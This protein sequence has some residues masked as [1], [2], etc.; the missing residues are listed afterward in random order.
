MKPRTS[1][2]AGPRCTARLGPLD[3]RTAAWREDLADIAL[4]PLIAVQAYSEPMVMRVRAKT[5]PLRDAP[6]ADAVAVSELLYGE[7]FAVFDATGGQVWGYGLHDHYVGYADL[8]V[9]E[10][11]GANA[12]GSEAAMVGPGDALVFAQPRLKAPVLATLPMAAQVRI[13]AHNEHFVQLAGGHHDGG[14]VHRRH[15]MHGDIDWVAIAQS[16]IGAPYRWGGRTR[17]G[18]DCSGLI[19]IAWQMAGRTARRDSDMLIADAGDPVPGGAYQRGDIAWWPGHI[20]V[21]LDAETLLHAN[22]HWMA[23]VQEPLADV[24]A[25]AARAGGVSEPVVKRPQ[26]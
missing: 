15:L 25:R 24:V 23:T 2:V 6:G 13:R 22:A 26:A 18:V 5:A 10:P 8:A 14:F 1:R 21:M 16:F 9:L 12:P 4:A 7:Q 3:P 17:A 19:Q 11:A 20:G